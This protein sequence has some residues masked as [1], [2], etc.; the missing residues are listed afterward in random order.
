MRSSTRSA[1]GKGA[2][3]KKPKQTPP[4]LPAKTKP[5]G[6]KGAGGREPTKEELKAQVAELQAQLAKGVER[7]G[8]GGSKAEALGA[9]KG[10]NLLLCHRQ[11]RRNVTYPKMRRWRKSPTGAFSRKRSFSRVWCRSNSCTIRS[12]L[13]SISHQATLAM[14]STPGASG[15]TP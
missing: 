1:S 14:A 5:S 11:L 15:P 9:A 3:T 13:R 4:K 12:C 8:Q 10:T 7:E 6:G 2:S